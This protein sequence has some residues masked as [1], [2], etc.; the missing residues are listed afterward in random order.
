[1]ADYYC[2]DCL[3]RVEWDGDDDPACEVCGGD[4]IERCD[5]N[6]RERGD[7]DGVEYADPRDYRDDRD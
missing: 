7:D 4:N 3:R 1:M 2:Q 6:P 5:E